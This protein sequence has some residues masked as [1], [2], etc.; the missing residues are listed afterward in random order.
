MKLGDAKQILEQ[1]ERD[2]NVN[3]TVKDSMMDLPD[4]DSIQLFGKFATP[5]HFQPDSNDSVT[6]E[7]A[8]ANLSDKDFQIITTVGSIRSN[9]IRLFKTEFKDDK[10]IKEIIDMIGDDI[11]IRLATSKGRGGWL[12]NLIISSKK[13]AEIATRSLGEAGKSI[14]NLG[15]K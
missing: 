14:F 12:G 15:K 6:R 2:Y 7:N 13:L 1:M 4:R 5:D 8:T 3:K 10:H 11:T 9:F